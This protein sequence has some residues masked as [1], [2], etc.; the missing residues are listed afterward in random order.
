MSGTI[1]WEQILPA[2]TAVVFIGG[3]LW[4]IFN[5]IYKDS[6]HTR[7]RIDQVSSENREAI[8]RLREDVAVRYVSN[9][10]HSIVANTVQ[11]AIDE[12]KAENRESIARMGERI[13]NSILHLSKVLSG[14]ESRP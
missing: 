1:S 12:L 4:A 11:R 6:N 8:A 9:E 14:R 13:D 10:T 3:V 5:W 2:I 7:T